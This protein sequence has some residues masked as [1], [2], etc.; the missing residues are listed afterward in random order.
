VKSGDIK[1]I[2]IPDK[3]QLAN[4]LTKGVLRLKFQW[5]LKEFGLIPWKRADKS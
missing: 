2:H 1:V 3:L 4:P 5:F